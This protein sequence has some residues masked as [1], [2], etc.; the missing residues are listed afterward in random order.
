MQGVYIH[1]HESQN[2][3]M[4][5]NVSLLTIMTVSAY[6]LVAQLYVLFQYIVWRQCK[7]SACID[8]SPRLLVRSTMSVC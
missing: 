1:W 2:A 3:S 7:G 4:Q 6:C 8:L 5:H